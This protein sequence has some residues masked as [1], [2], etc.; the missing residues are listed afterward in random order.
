MAILQSE[1]L[2]V[3]RRGDE[4]VE[5]CRQAKSDVGCEKV[6]FGGGLRMGWM[7]FLAGSGPVLSCCAAGP[8]GRS[9][10]GRLVQL[11]EDTSWCW[12]WKLP[13]AMCRSED[14]TRHLMGCKS[15]RQKTKKLN[16]L[17]P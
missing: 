3:G 10:V 12:L 11:K 1:D 14:Q 4:V 5:D 8:V 6:S 15:P 13:L 2:E 16:K 17:M 9:S 7:E